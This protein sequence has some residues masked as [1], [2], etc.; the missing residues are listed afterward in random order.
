MCTCLQT[1][2][3]ANSLLCWFR[4]GRSSF[5]RTKSVRVTLQQ[6]A[7]SVSLADDA[8]FLRNHWL[9]VT[10][11][12][13]LHKKI[14]QELFPV[15]WSRDLTNKQ[16][17]TF[18]DSL[19]KRTKY[20]AVDP[21]N[22]NCPPSGL[23]IPRKIIDPEERITTYYANVFLRVEAVGCEELLDDKPKKSIQLLCSLLQPGVLKK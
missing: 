10:Q 5:S 11:V 16:I 17:R 12:F 4:H 22:I 1:C 15:D 23:L 14:R 7:V 18:P 20:E 19:I 6:H 13:T 2:F 21:K 8:A 3:F 9:L